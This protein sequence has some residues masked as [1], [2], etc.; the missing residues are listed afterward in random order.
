MSKLIKFALVVDKLPADDTD[1]WATVVCP[2]CGGRICRK[3]L[4][5]QFPPTCEGCHAAWHYEAIEPKDEDE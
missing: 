2:F 5:P 4:V 3:E 1:I